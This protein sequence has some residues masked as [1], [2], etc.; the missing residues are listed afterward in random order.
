MDF[1]NP[2]I[3]IAVIATASLIFYGIFQLIRFAFWINLF[4]IVSLVYF[5]TDSI[6]LT[7]S[8]LYFACPILL[9]NT[10]LFVFFQKGTSSSEAGSKYEVH[11]KSNHGDFKIQNIRRGASIIGAAGSGKTESVVYGFL[12]H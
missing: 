5:L 2:I 6:G 4:I 10:V 3:I 11:F 9:I 7:N 1:N 8:L 12:K